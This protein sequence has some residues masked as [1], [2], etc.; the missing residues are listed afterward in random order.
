MSDKQII[1]LVEELIAPYQLLDSDKEMLYD[2]Y[3]KYPES[4]LLESIKTGMRQ[5][6]HY[7]SDGELTSGSVAMFLDK[8]GGIVYHK[9]LDP[10]EQEVKHIK[11]ICRKYFEDFDNADFDLIFQRYIEALRQAGFSDESIIDDFQKDV[12]H[13]CQKSSRWR[14]LEKWVSGWI[15]DLESNN[16]SSSNTAH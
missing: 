2:L 11:S 15:D 4:L 8:L 12:M 14:Q 6:F 5:Y 13:A 16:N 3:H 1:C 7:N 9:S 10:I